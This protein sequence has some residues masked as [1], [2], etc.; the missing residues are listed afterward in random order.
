LNQR[1]RSA[2]FLFLL[3]LIFS[4]PAFAASADVPLSTLTA[5]P[6]P[7]ASPADSPTLSNGVD[8]SVTGGGGLGWCVAGGCGDGSGSSYFQWRP[9]AG[10]QVWS[11]SSP[12]NLEFTVTGLQGG[13]SAGVQEGVVLPQGTICNLSTLAPAVASLFSFD[14][15]TDPTKPTLAHI[16]PSLTPGIGNLAETAHIPCTLN[17]TTTL[18]LDGTG[19]YLDFARGLN[20][21]TVIPA[22]IT[23]A[24]SNL[25]K[26]LP[27]GETAT[28]VTLTCK[29][30]GPG[31]DAI[32]A[33]CVPSVTNGGGT[34]SS[35]SCTPG[36]LPVNPLQ[37]G[38]AI[39]CTFDLT[40]PN[41]P[42]VDIQLQGKATADGLNDAVATGMTA[43]ARLLFPA[44]GAAT[45][46]TLGQWTL[47]LLALLTLGGAALG[48]RRGQG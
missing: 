35:L 21:L 25:P 8:W 14:D 1:P 23:A 3:A 37:D 41:T 20:S 32:N 42:T 12:V 44:A 28:G 4:A 45:V 17:N 11:F 31:P 36:A 40:A 15:T 33:N 38:D 47:A 39:V 30:D 48:M 34:I 5:A 6:P 27:P 19:F 29:N 46:P 7:L 2:A 9:N 13:L 24:F 16:G 10:N 26:S 22:T 43:G 18:T